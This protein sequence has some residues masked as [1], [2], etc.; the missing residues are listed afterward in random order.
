M[1]EKIITGITLFLI[2]SIS[3]FLLEQVNGLTQPVIIEARE[4]RILNAYGELFPAIDTFEV[5]E[6]EHE[7]LRSRVDVLD[8]SGNLLGFIYEAGKVNDHGS[9]GLLIGIGV[10]GVVV[11]YVELEFNQTPGISAPARKG[12]YGFTYINQPIE[13][14]YSDIDV[15]IG[16]TKSATTLLELFSE[17]SEYHGGSL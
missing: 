6:L 17:V 3:G 14:D 11:D 10:D 12:N 13:R 7:V 9:I 4:E 15:K 8:D 16:A 1:K 2:A 5:T